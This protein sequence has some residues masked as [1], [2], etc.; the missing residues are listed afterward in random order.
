MR[1]IFIF[2][3]LLFLCKFE[4]PTASAQKTSLTHSPTAAESEETETTP[5]PTSEAEKYPGK[6]GAEMVFIPEGS[7]IMGTDDGNALTSSRPAHE[8]TL[9]DYWIDRYEVSNA[10]YAE[11]VKAKFC[12]LPKELTSGTRDDY[13]KNSDYAN[14]PVIHVNHQQASAYCEWAG[15]RLP[16]EAEWEKAARGEQGFLYPWGN[17]LP[18]EIPAQINRFQSG[19]TAPVDSF[20]EGASPYGIFN[21]EGNVW[22]WTADQFDEFWYS[23]SP[24]DNPKASFGINDYVIRG[25]SWAYPFSRYEITIRNAFY[26]LNHTYDLGFRCAYSE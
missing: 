22:E 12:T 21:M 17:N 7:F 6:D 8:V 2:I 19:D 25:F 1:K 26:I 14:Y 16:T 9:R 23:S 4:I 18:D 3:I 15:K 24:S 20:P 10:Q 11:C 13:Y 5:E